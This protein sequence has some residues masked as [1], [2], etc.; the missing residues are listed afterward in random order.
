MS[1]IESHDTLGQ[2]PKTL[3]L[4]S[5]LNTDLPQTVGL[6]HLLWHF[7]LKYAW[8][9]GDLSGYSNAVIAQA[10]G[11]RGDAEQLIKCLQ[12]SG[13]MDDK[14]VHDWLDFAGRIVDGRIYNEKRRRKTAS[15]AVKVRKTSATVPTVPTV[16][17]TPPIV[18][19]K[20]DVKDWFERIW[21]AYPAERRHGKPV[22]LRR[23]TKTVKSYDDAKRCVR[24]LEGYLAS[25][26]VGKGYILRGS[27]WF[28][29]WEDHANERRDIPRTVS[30]PLRRQPA[31]EGPSVRTFV[32]PARLLSELANHVALGD[33]AKAESA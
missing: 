29:E 28:E 17:T 16:P 23:F 6:L 11:W 10:I 32:T 30:A 12:E 13:W 19:Q 15:N 22:A 18:P 24:A 20:G 3:A 2:H 8:R 26:A 21:K 4:M 5:A 1:W 9:K 31:E 27:K 25:E 7:T 14:R 33:P